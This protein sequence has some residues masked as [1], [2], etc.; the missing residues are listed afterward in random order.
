VVVTT[1]KDVGELDV[2]NTGKPYPLRI[3][4]KGTESGALT[5]SDFGTKQPI[6]A[7]PSPIQVSS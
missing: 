2:A 7:P 6:T 3:T 4:N 1:Q 5:F